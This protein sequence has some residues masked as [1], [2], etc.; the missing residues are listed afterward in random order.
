MLPVEIQNLQAVSAR[1]RSR[2]ARTGSHDRGEEW[3]LIHVWMIDPRTNQFDKFATGR[4]SKP[5]LASIHVSAI[6]LLLT[7][8]VVK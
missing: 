4:D 2:F 7:H 6:K 3:L 5:R 8:T 1:L